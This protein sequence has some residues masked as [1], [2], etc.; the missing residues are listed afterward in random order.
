MEFI[1]MKSG[2]VDSHTP[3]FAYMLYVARFMSPIPA[4]TEFTPLNDGARSTKKIR[5]D[6]F[7]PCNLPLPAILLGGFYSFHMIFILF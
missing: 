4:H 3:S 7:N 6:Q 2:V 1:P 5:I